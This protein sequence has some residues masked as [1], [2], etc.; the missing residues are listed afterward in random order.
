MIGTLYNRCIIKVYFRLTYF[1]SFTRKDYLL[2]LLKQIRIERYFPMKRLFRNLIVYYLFKS[3][4]N[5][6]ADKST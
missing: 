4:F 5:C 2:H 6:F 3:S 1:M